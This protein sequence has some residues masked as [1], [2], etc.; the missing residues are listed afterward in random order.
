MSEHA[1]A[2]QKVWVDE[3]GYLRL[4]YKGDYHRA[5]SLVGIPIID[6]EITI[7]G[8]ID[9]LCAALDEA[10]QW[11][12]IEEMPPPTEVLNKCQQALKKARGEA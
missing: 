11:N 9:E 6:K 1:T 12:W 3:H 5:I 10:M 8:L 2:L 7:Q 4:D